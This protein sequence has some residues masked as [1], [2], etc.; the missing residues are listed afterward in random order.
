[1]VDFG[2]TKLYVLRTRPAILL[3]FVFMIKESDSS[4]IQEKHLYQV[5]LNNEGECQLLS[6]RDYPT[7]VQ[8]ICVVATKHI[9]SRIERKI[10]LMQEYRTALISKVVTGNVSVL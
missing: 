10:E 1:M 3:K 9:I 2:S 6:L 4:K 7:T 8:P 5:R